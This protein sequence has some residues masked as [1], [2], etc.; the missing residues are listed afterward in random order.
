MGHQNVAC[1]WKIRRLPRVA[2]DLRLPGLT[3]IDGYTR[4]RDVRVR[5]LSFRVSA[6][7]RAGSGC[8]RQQLAVFKRKQNR[9]KLRGL[10]RLFWIALR[11]LWRGW[12]ESLILVKPATVVSW[13]R[14]GFRLFGLWAILPVPEGAPNPK[15]VASATFLRSKP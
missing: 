13:H 9:P 6:Q 14:A 12:I 7:T 15:G 4:S 1:K 5:P 10:D 11:S 8:T 3:S 2:S